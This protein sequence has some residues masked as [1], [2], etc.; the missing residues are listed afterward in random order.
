MKKDLNRRGFFKSLSNRQK[1]EILRAPYWK[2]LEDFALCS[3]CKD[4]PCINACEEG[5]IHLKDGTPVISFKNSG[6]TYCD[7]CAKVCG[8]GVLFVEEKRQIGAIFSINTTK[9][10]AWNDVV[11][12]SCKDGCWENAIEFFGLFRPMVNDKCTSCGFCVA[13]CPVGA[14][15][16]RENL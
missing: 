7:E 13:P 1:G 9:C 12:S 15:D 5:I 6:C 8:M 2:D 11:C 3:T 10:L 14:F 4:T 16:I